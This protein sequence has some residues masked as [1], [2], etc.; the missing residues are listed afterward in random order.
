MQQWDLTAANVGG[1]T[2]PQVLFSTSEARGVVISLDQ[3]EEMGD[4]QVRERALLHILRGSV[5]CTSGVDAATCA[6]GTLIVFEPGEPHSVRALQPTRLLVVLVPWPGLGHY[7]DAEGE[8]PHE[9]PVN[10]TQPPRSE[11]PS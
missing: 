2:G 1:R 8:N 4:H 3:G 6:E 5:T 11:G 10:A 7:D 9:L